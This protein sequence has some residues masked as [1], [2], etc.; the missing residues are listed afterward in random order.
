MPRLCA[1]WLACALLGLGTVA[2]AQTPPPKPLPFPRPGEPPIKPGPADP[3]AQEQSPA[4]APGAG[5]PT[6]ATLG[7]PVYPGA[8]FVASFDAGKGQRYYLYGTLVPFADIV[9][10]YK[11]VLK[12][13]GELVFDEPAMHLFEIGRF[14]EETM[15]F[16]PGV[17]VKD[18]TWNGSSGYLNPKPGGTP[19]RFPTII[20]IVPAPPGGSR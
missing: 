1:A 11:A 4:P 2:A 19:A 10:Y 8:Q 5:E 12:Q 3:V 20:Q 17:T 7:V 14:R 18:Y 9:N 13:R 6:E 16:P 15:A